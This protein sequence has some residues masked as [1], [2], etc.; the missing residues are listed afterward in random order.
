MIRLAP[1]EPVDLQYQIAGKVKIKQE[2]T[3]TPFLMLNREI[4]VKEF[5]NFLADANYPDEEKPKVFMD[6]SNQVDGRSCL[7]HIKD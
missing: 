4:T 5:R 7:G 3:P 6:L 2:K 1:R